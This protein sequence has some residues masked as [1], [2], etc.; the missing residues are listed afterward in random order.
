MKA[1]QLEL[2]QIKSSLNEAEEN[3]T[4]LSLEL[5]ELSE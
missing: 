1:L 2:D 4:E 3:W 5:E